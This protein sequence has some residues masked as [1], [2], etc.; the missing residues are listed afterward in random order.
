MKYFVN[1]VEQRIDECADEYRRIFIQF[2]DLKSAVI[3]FAKESQWYK[4]KQAT[5][6]IS[7]PIISTDVLLENTISI[8]ETIVIITLREEE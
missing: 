3:G 8:G 4:T 5:E 6:S 7:T 1:V 2:S